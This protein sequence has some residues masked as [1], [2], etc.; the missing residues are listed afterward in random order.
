M[1]VAHLPVIP[2]IQDIIL[3]EIHAIHVYRNVPLA[4]MGLPVQIVMEVIEKLQIVYAELDIM[5]VEILIV[6]HVL[7]SVQ[8]V[9]LA[10][11]V[12]GAKTNISW[13]VENANLVCQN[14]PPV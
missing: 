14:V 7:L 10:Q 9:Q 1:I 5:M 6:V 8:V 12:L 3:V 11:I 2:V 13:K 4:M